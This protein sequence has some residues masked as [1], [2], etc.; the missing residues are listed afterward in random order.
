MPAA[1]TQRIA[2]IMTSAHFAFWI[3]RLHKW[4]GLIVAA[5]LLIWTA[6]GLFFTVFAIERI[7]GDDLFVKPDATPV[8]LSRVNITLEQALEEVAEDRPTTATLRNLGPDPVY[9]VR[10]AIGVFLVSAESGRIVSPIQEQTARNILEAAWRGEGALTSVELL[11]DAPRETG[12]TG[13][14]WAGTFEGKGN[15]TL[16]VNASTGAVGPVRTDLWRT[17]DFLWALHI[18]DYSEREN[19]NHPLIIAAAILA[20]SVVLFGITLLIQ[21]ATRGVLFR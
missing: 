6:T 3:G 20:L 8:D 14:I 15:P 9:E 17:Y 10:A 12:Q 1:R 13:K 11:E 18:M 19:F 21:R 5:Q 2:Q 16:Y 7:R 4:L